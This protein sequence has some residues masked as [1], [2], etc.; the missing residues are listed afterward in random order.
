[1]RE[2][3]PEHVRRMLE[4]C[5]HDGAGEV[6]ASR[7]WVEL[8]DHCAELAVELDTLGYHPIAQRVDRDYARLHTQLRDATAAGW[9][10]SRLLLGDAIEEFASTLAAIQ[11]FRAR[12]SI[13]A[14][15][16]AVLQ[17]LGD[18]LET[19]IANASDR[20]IRDKCRAALGNPPEITQ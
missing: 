10:Q 5:R 13:P 15:D 18:V 19:V 8:R 17:D 12:A 14:G 2:P 3:Y 1:M 20:R 7:A 4:S 16:E 11:R 9:T 6:L